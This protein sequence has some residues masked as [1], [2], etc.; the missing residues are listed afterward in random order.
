[1]GKNPNAAR[2]KTNHRKGKNEDDEDQLAEL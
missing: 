1:M 2:N